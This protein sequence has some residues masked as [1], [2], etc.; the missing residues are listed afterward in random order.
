MQ[1]I[2]I[3]ILISLNNF[4]KFC[5]FLT[6]KWAR[7]QKIQNRER[8]LFLGLRARA[9][10]ILTSAPKLWLFDMIPWINVSSFRF[11]SQVVCQLLSSN[12]GWFDTCYYQ[13]THTKAKYVSLIRLIYKYFI[14]S[15]MRIQATTLRRKTEKYFVHQFITSTFSFLCCRVKYSWNKLKCIF[16]VTGIKSDIVKKP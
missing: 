15:T 2:F 8:N 3:F 14:L 16:L 6:L 9:Q 5:D 7:A 10:P 12:V 13:I 11:F 1:E 4:G